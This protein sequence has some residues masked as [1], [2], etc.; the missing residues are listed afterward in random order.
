MTP[1][2]DTVKGLGHFE[3]SIHIL[4]I[5]VYYEDTDLSGV[6]Y[7]ANYLRFMERARTE[8]FRSVGV[9]KM[10]DLESP[11]PT[12]WTI[13]ELAIKY[14]YPARLDDALEVHTICT[15][16]S[17]ARLNAIQR[18]FCGD[19]LLTEGRIEA[20]VITLTGRP[21]RIPQHIRDLLNPFLSQ[22]DV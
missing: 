7:H 8:L 17:G 20:C 3:G 4:P 11:E 21:R 19:T 6:V 9:S 5:R 18:V 16:V 22:T 2:S 13:R 10:A 15:A 14:I 1:M 12:A